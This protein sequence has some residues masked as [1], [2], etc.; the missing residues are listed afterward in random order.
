MVAEL[1]H[2]ADSPVA[3]HALAG[4]QVLERLDASAD[5]LSDAQ[6]QSR[7]AHHFAGHHLADHAVANSLGQYGQLGGAGHGPGL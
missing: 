4:E 3:W 7:L 6:A 2:K 5:G 1:I